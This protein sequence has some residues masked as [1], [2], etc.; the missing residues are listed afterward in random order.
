MIK[1]MIV[2]KKLVLLCLAVFAIASVSA[3]TSNLQKKVVEGS[4]LL[5]QRN[6]SDDAK[7]L[8]SRYL[9]QSFLE[10][11]N[12]LYTLESKKR[13]THSTDIHYLYLDK[14]FK[15]IKTN[16]ENLISKIE[17]S[18]EIVRSRKGRER[19]EV[20]N[21]L[22]MIINLMTD[23]H[24]I[25]HVRLESVPHSMQ[26]FQI[27][28]WKGDTPKYKKGKSTVNWSK[29]GYSYDGKNGV[30]GAMWAAD[31]EWAY[32]DKAKEFAAGSLYDWAADMGNLANEMYKWAVPG[33]EMSRLQRNDLADL[34]Y[35]LRAKLAYRFV[36]MFESLVK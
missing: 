36:T 2:M 13:A 30:T 10:D 32:G 3:Q 33:Y 35:E 20:A 7:A 28:C 34:H 24:T 16:P 1:N 25:G 23:M 15:P 29:L 12:A 26:D 14:D 9:G 4:I 22:R 18:M 5:A 6:I 11:V 19:T 21:A 31:H 8:L 17:E 27:F